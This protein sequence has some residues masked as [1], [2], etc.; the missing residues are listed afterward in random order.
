MMPGMFFSKKTVSLPGNF[1]TI[2]SKPVLNRESL[3]QFSND[4]VFAMA[5]RR[6]SI[7]DLTAAGHQPMASPDGR[8]WITYNGEIYNLIEL[9]NSLKTKGY[10]FRSRTDTEVVLAQ[11]QEYGPD[12][13][14]ALNGMFAF[15]V[16]DRK[17]RALTLV[18]DRAGIKPV[19]YS[20]SKDHL[21]FGSEIKA[22]LAS[23]L[24]ESRIN[25]QALVEYFTFQNIFSSETLFNRVLILEPGTFLTVNADGRISKPQSYVHSVYDSSIQNLEEA[26]VCERLAGYFEKAVQRQ[27]AADVEVGSYL[28]GG[29]DSGSIVA[30]ASQSIPRLL[31]FTV[32]FDLT[33][34]S[35]LEQGFD[36]RQP[37]ERLSHLFQTEHYDVVLHSG[38]MPAAMDRLAW[39]MDDPRVGMCHPNWYASKL[40]SR[41][42]KVCLSGAGGDELFGGYPW[43]YENMLKAASVEESDQICFKYWHRLLAP[44]EISDLFHPDFR[45]QKAKAWNSFQNVMSG[46]PGWKED[47]SYQENLLQRVLY[48]EYKTFLHGLLVTEDRMSMAHGVEARVPFLDNDLMEFAWQIRPSLKFNSSMGMPKETCGKRVLRKA[49]SRYLPSEFTEQPKKGFSPPD[50]SWYRGPSMEYIKTILLD[51]KTT[52]RPWFDS[53]F[54]EQ[55]LREHFEGL[56]N[57]RL[58]IWSLLS[59]ELLQRHFLDPYSQ[60][61]KEASSGYVFQ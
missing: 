1:P 8:Y 24:I 40:A 14:A 15:A 10:D 46:A 28:S 7:L 21:I 9:R 30:I 38:D 35:G 51:A 5:H 43:R 26:S 12:G 42:V 37:A 17:T 4:I 25:P 47:W 13:L 19:Y 6:L 31:T 22:I 60:T 54:I 57:H 41:F 16:F 36:E 18:R 34:V 50:G 29:M 49:M 11:W 56:R 3:N 33:N 44:E 23:G 61:A 32:G 52:T 2:H 58:L 53:N 20:F 45:V 48:F 59:V 55:K 27:L 39:H